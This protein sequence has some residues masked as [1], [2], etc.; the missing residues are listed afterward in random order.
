[1]NTLKVAMDEL[2]NASQAM[3][4]YAED[5]VVQERYRAAIEVY[6]HKIEL[7]SNL[8]H[9]FLIKHQA[10]NDKIFKEAIEYLDI[11]MEYAN[12]ELAESAL[13]LINTIRE[14]EPEFFDTYYKIRFGK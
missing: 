8:A 7:Q 5:N 4:L 10:V 14:K 1:M 11:A 13:K 2:S 3:Q 6:R 9:D 12:I